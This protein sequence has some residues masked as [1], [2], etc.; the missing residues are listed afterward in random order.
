M[1]Y[2]KNKLTFWIWKVKEF[3]NPDDLIFVEKR[4]SR[5][6]RINWDSM[7]GHYNERCIALGHEGYPCNTRGPKSRWNNEGREVT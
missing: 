5:C 7:T 6:K 2:I 1:R 3:F 4:C